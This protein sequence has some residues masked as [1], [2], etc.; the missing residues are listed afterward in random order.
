MAVKTLVLGTNNLKKRLELEELLDL[1]ELQL[2]TLREFGDV[3]EV[4]EDGETFID[5]AAKKAVQLAKHLNQ[6]VLGEDSGLAVDAL[7]GAPG[8][9]S[10]RYAGEPC[11]DQANNDKLLSELQGVAE[12]DRGAHYVCTIMVA[13][14]TGEIRAKAEG[15]CDGRIAFA[16]AGS[17][18]FG[19]DPLFILAGQDK[20]FGELPAEVKHA[21]SHRA[22]AVRQLRPLLQQLLTLW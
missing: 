10:A 22:A 20:T 9:Y 17:N 14:P 7:G 11:D 3:P 8:V 21:H 6:W 15:R 19:Y 1:P 16:P 5:N 13:D 18:G 12:P 2:Q 4:V